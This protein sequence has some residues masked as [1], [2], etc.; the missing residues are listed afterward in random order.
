MTIKLW[1]FVSGF[2][3]PVFVEHLG[4]AIL[5][6]IRTDLIGETLVHG[7]GA[8][9]HPAE[10]PFQNIGGADGFAAL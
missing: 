7:P 4:Y 1:K 2:I 5:D 9:A 6:T 8:P 10:S 3:P